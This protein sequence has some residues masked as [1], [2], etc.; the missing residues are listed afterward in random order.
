MVIAA[1]AVAAA[2][3]CVGVPCWMWYER[4]GCFTPS[5]DDYWKMDEY[6]QI[7][8]KRGVP[9]SKRAVAALKQKKTLK[10]YF[11]EEFS[12]P[13]ID[14]KSLLP[15]REALVALSIGDEEEG[16]RIK[17]T[18]LDQ[19]KHFEKL[20]DVL[21]QLD[22][23]QEVDIDLAE[24]PASLKRL[25]FKG[26]NITFSNLKELKAALGRF[27]IITDQEVNINLEELPAS[28]NSLTLN[29][30]NITP[31]NLEHTLDHLKS[32]SRLDLDVVDPQGKPIS[33]KAWKAN[34]G[35]S[36]ELYEALTD[37]EQI[38]AFIAGYKASLLGT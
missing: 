14:L 22:N 28:V 2:L 3:V 24:L 32:L 25:T 31:S 18:H 13:S 11:E 20:E 9:L 5:F 10:L 21:I 33:T 37:C 35:L 26:Q 19:L 12:D 38:K 29:G 30:Q 16:I 4:K 8:L 1:S 23:D 17:C 34:N 36:V 27:H 15:V 6:D 7:Y